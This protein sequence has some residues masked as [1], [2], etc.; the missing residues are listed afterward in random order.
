MLLPMIDKKI[1]CWAWNRIYI[2][3]NG[4][5]PCWCDSGETHTISDKDFET[6]DFVPDIVNSEE[7]CRMRL[8]LLRDSQQYIKECTSCCCLLTQD[9]AKFKRYKD[10]EKATNVNFQA[11]RA[12]EELQQV[13]YH[14]NW[15]L[16]SIDKI[17]EIQLEPS[18][19]CNLHCPGCLH[20][21]HPNPLQTEKGPY[22]FP[23]EWF[24]KLVSS[25]L[26]HKVDVKRI[27]FVGRGE[28]TLNKQFPEII[29]YSKQWLPTTTLSMDT[30]ATQ[31]FK[32]EYLLLDWINCSID[33]S[34]EEAYK[35]YRRGGNFNSTLNFM[36]EA[37]RT[38]KETHKN[39]RIRWKYILFDTSESVELL[40]KAQHLASEIG[41]DELDFVITACGAADGSVTP[42]KV[43]NTIDKMNEYIQSNPIFPT[44]IVSRS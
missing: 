23:L 27:A 36:R 39:C 21:W 24:H 18:F 14:R 28:P 30:N 40:N 42:P 11:N 32:D 34:T 5:A 9:K 20:G 25:V 10:S 7:M 16:G 33:G 31:P 1:F 12:F 2:K 22:V 29:K 37:A 6:S 3:A 13:S 19:P 43:M 44:T 35:T 17:S 41:I 38:K 8:V 4:R 26:E 15:K